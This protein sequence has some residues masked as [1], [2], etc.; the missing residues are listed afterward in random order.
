MTQ[1]DEE[2]NQRYRSLLDEERAR[3][4]ELQKQIND[5]HGGG[6]EDE[7]TQL[8]ELSTID[9][10]PADAG[11]EVFERERDLSLLA[12]FE[13]QVAE[14]DA[15]LKRL[16]DGSF[17]SCERCGKEIPKE[18]LTAIPWARFCVDDQAAAERSTA[19]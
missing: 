4:E 10:H 16:E 6:N 11:T 15:A 19:G 8:S 1:L 13:G 12:R 9:Q 3:L 5:D 2:A 17:G 7:Q 14:V 18:R